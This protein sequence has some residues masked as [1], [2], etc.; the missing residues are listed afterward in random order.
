MTKGGTL[1]VESLQP[2]EY[3]VA[4]RISDTGGGMPPEVLERIFE[5]FF[6]TKEQGK[7]TGLGLSTSD[8]IIRQHGG[9]LLVTSVE[10]EGTTFEI[11]LPV[12]RTHVSERAPVVGEITAVGGSETILLVEDDSAVAQVMRETLT[13]K[14]YAVLITSS[15]AEALVIAREFPGEIHLLLSDMVLRGGF[16]ID[17]AR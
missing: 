8:S 12:A 17:I 14:G 1:T 4:L 15:G 10:G 7:G 13:A 5:P 9:E 2:S 16:G 3:Q 11:R 6:T